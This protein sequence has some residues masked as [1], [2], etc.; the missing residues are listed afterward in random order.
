MSRADGD[1]L[2]F[3]AVDL[4][5]RLIPSAID[6]NESKILWVQAPAEGSRHRQLLRR[7]KSEYHGPH[8][9]IHH[10]YR[11]TYP[12]H[13]PRNPH[14]K[15]ATMDHEKLARMQNAVRIGT[16]STAPPPST[17]S[18]TQTRLQDDRMEILTDAQGKNSPCISPTDTPCPFPSILDPTRASRMP[19]LSLCDSESRRD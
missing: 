11:P 17:A 4:L 9:Y 5:A 19:R 18:A 3:A 14:I 1:V 8:S 12:L 10:F 7:D 13:P 6:S 15:P 16:L 2:S